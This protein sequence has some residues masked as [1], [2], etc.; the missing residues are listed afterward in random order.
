[1]SLPKHHFENMLG[2]SAKFTAESS[3]DWKQLFE[4]TGIWRA[5]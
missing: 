2:V 1:M 4:T 5:G 3:E